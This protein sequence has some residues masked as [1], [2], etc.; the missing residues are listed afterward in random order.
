[1]M[2]PLSNDFKIMIYQILV[3]R[4]WIENWTGNLI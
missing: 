1:M 3:I 4:E 2:K